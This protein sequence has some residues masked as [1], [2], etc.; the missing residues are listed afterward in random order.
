MIKIVTQALELGVSQ[1]ELY[2]SFKSIGHSKGFSK[3]IICIKKITEKK[4][5]QAR[6]KRSKKPKMIKRNHAA[7]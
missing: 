7:G 3:F 5:L 1:S 4:L 2:Y 6:P